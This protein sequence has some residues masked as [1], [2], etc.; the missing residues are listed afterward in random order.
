VR[1][2]RIIRMADMQVKSNPNRNMFC[3]LLKMYAKTSRG[4]Y[5]PNYL[6]YG[7]FSYHSAYWQKAT[8]L[9]E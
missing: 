4:Q 7:V 6:L 1:P 2:V 5:L 8:F 3:L 9:V